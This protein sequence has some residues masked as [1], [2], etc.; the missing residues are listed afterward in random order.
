[1]KLNRVFSLVIVLALVLA[2]APAASAQG[3]LGTWVSGIACQNLDNAN[4]AL[5][6]LHFYPEGSGT[7]ALDYDDTIPAGA[8]KNYYTPSSPPGLP[9]TFLGSVMV[10]SSTPLACNVNTQT[11]G[12]GTSTSPYR[13]GTSAGFADSETGL[14]MYAPQVMKLLGGAWSSYIA[15]QN[16][17]AAEITVNLSYRD[18]F[19][20]AVPAAD[21]SD[22]IPGYSNHVFYQADNAGLAN[23]FIGAATIVATGNIAVVTN[24]Y[25]A[26]TDN[27]NAQLHSYNGFSSGSDTLLVP[28]FVRKFYG[29]NG[30]MSIQ[31]IGAAP[32]TV[33]IDF[34]FAGNTYTYDSPA[35]QPGAALALYSKDMPELAPVDGLPIGQRFGSAV[36]TSS[37]E[38]IIAIINEDNRG[39]AGDNNG[40][41][42]PAE[43]VGQGNTYNAILDGAQTVTIFFPQIVARASNI[44]SGGFQVAN[45]TGTSSP[46]T[47]T[48]NA[49]AGLDF[50]FTLGAFGSASIYAENVPG[51]VTPYNG[52]VTVVCSQA[53]VGISNLAAF[54]GSGKLG[55]SL[56]GGNG[57]NR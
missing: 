17:T 4:A 53:I 34:T 39:L 36:I 5:I 11:T 1:M 41:A 48:F 56:S 25:N 33:S 14:K 54:P 7:A 15:V 37:G 20:A 55:D 44:F 46:C 22:T 29:Y 43:R 38:D 28:R 26:G 12:T 23:G 13:I 18:R 8:S 6:T 42:V 47:A 9:A 50:D 35:I 30:G 10:E 52:S 32:T 57:L 51:I 49:Q 3:P 40:S 27:T 45:T 19:G 16:A 24:F 2:L 31:N 21:E